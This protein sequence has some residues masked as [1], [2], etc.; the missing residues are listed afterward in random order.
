M[1]RL[2]TGKALF[3]KQEFEKAIEV[4]SSFLD[5]EKDNADALYTRAICYRKIELFDKS[6]ADLSTILIRLPEEATL[7][8]DRGISHFK[9][10]NIEAAML[11]MDKAVELEPNNPF[12]Y[13]SRA[14]IRAN[15]DIKGAIADYEKTIELDPKDDIAY[16]NLGLL[17]ENA[18]KMSSAKNNF[19]K[20]D[21]ISGY[22]PE[23]RVDEIK[24][25]LNEEEENSLGKTA[26]SIFT[27]K[28]ARKEYFQFI[29]SLFKKKV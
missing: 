29:K 24:K 5:D 11:D 3:E 18:G 21:K 27:S 15:I 25:D 20:A 10:K 6:I 8:C 16:N 13:S 12:R 14:Y 23:K 4:L 19:K 9:N 7:L 28:R 26:L 22:N 1:E 2:K 17:Q